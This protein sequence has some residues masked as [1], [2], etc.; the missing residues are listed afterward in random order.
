MHL[1]LSSSSCRRRALLSLRRS[2]PG[3]GAATSLGRPDWRGSGAACKC[4]C[5]SKAR[6]AMGGHGGPWKAM[7]GRKRVGDLGRSH[8]GFERNSIFCWTSREAVSF[9]P[10]VPI[11]T[12]HGSV[13]RTRRVAARDWTSC[14]HV[15]EKSNVWRRR[16][17]ILRTAWICCSKG[18][19]GQSCGQPCGQP[20]GQTRAG[21][22]DVHSG[23]HGMKVW[24]EERG[25]APTCGSKPRSSIR[26]AS[27]STT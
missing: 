7:E 15:A 25:E 16:P 6:E 21:K 22:E 18:P 13:G 19:C 20:C 10:P 26:S 24:G 17:T 2:S 4:T 8:A 5:E 11:V 14:G 12:R 3:G 23:R 1:R 9:S 27:S